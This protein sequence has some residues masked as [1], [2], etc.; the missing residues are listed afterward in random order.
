MFNRTET[1]LLTFRGPWGV[2]IEIAPS[3]LLLALVFV[4]FAPSQHGLIFFGIVAVSI[5]LHELGHAWGALVQG[6]P[7][8]RIVLW[9]G[10]GF[11]E[12]HRA[13]TPRETE[14][15]VA[16][17]P[18]TNLALWAVGSLIGG[19]IVDPYYATGAE[20]AW[21]IG[22]YVELFATTNLVLFALN[23]LP[24]QPLDGGK[25]LH[26]GLGRVIDAGRATRITGAVGLVLAVL[27]V[28]A[29]IGAWL[30]WG[31]ALLF[32]PSIAAHY[33]MMRDRAWSY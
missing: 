27:W 7:V 8:R 22:W 14:L 25:L 28:P 4:G 19:A 33:A 6:Q 12:R 3:F 31:Y 29:M 24:V 2:P 11:C 26:L 30:T 5:L 13:A 18:L 32:I 17:G 10:G 16:M 9:G 21:Y 20:A 1:P 23:L 15:I